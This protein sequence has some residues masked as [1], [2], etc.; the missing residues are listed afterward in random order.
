QE[1][2]IAME[3]L[4]AIGEMAAKVAHEI[5]TPLVTIGGFSRTLWKS[6]P[7][8]APQREYLEIIRE[9]VRRLERFVSEILEYVKPVKIETQPC[10]VNAIVEGA[11]RSHEEEMRRVGI[12]LIRRLAD[13]LPPAQIDRYQIHQV[14]TN[15]IL[16]A[17]QSM[18]HSPV[19]ARRL[20]VTTE[21][22]DHHVRIS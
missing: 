4:S 17:I 9:E 14:L 13:G 12:E 7:E 19:Q 1:K 5:R 10:A 11:L 15:L 8:D 2:I 3:K 6:M 20:T 22:G 16:N 21:A 18:E